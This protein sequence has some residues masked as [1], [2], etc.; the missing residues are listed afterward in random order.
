MSSKSIGLTSTNLVLIIREFTWI[1]F[2]DHFTSRAGIHRCVGGWIRGLWLP[3]ECNWW[4]LG[5]G[6]MLLYRSCLKT[7]TKDKL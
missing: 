1:R 6:L 5:D 3:G 2:N 7:E 4:S